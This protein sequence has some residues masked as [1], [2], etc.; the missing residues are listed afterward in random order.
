MKLTA[1]KRPPKLIFGKSAKNEVVQYILPFRI[2]EPILFNFL[3]IFLKFQIKRIFYQALLEEPMGYYTVQNIIE[4]FL[5]STS[6]SHYT[7]TYHLALRS[8]S[9]PSVLMSEG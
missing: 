4:P 2:K 6:T 1:E 7:C 8:E 5:R 3:D 9:L